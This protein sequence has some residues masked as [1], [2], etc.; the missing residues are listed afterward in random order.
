MS[1]GS[2]WIWRLSLVVLIVGIGA[3]GFFGLSQSSL[4]AIDNITVDGNHA[5]ATNQILATVTP[6]LKGRSL[7]S[8]SFDDAGRALSQF[9]FIERV[10]VQ[11]DFP[12]TIHL[13][14]EERQP[15][16]YLATGG[17]NLFLSADGY[18]LASKPAPDPAFPLLTV[19]GPCAADPGQK[20]DCPDVNQGVRFLGNIP[21]DFDQQI[22]SANV[23]DGDI[24]ART[25]ANIN[26]HFG[27][28]DNYNFKFE[29]LKQLIARSVAGG[30]IDVSVPDRP[31]TKQPS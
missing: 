23:Y 3:G 26:I 16:A 31:V 24:S 2:R 11:R 6:L 25:K 5:V 4:L 22:A 9:P 15:L 20:I 7:L 14:V 19:K 8:F 18:V 13:H 21:V 10:D 12:H 1:T 17:G 28:L 27:T 29:V 30:S